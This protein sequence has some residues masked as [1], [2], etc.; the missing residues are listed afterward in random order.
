MSR[1]LKIYDPVQ[2]FLRWKANNKW[3]NVECDQENIFICRGP[4]PPTT[5][6]TIIPTVEAAISESMLITV[7]SVISVLIASLTILCYFDQR[8]V[9]KVKKKVLANRAKQEQDEELQVSSIKIEVEPLEEES[10]SHKAES[11]H[12]EDEA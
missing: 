9:K 5:A 3:N 11:K 10:M 6:S 7:T 8:S 12:E 4:C 1:F 2:F